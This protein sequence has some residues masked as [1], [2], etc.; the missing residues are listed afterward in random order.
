MGLAMASRR[1]RKQVATLPAWAVKPPIDTKLIDERGITPER[2]AQSRGAS[3]WGTDER[4][5]KTIQTMRD[6]PFENFYLRGGLTEKQYSAGVKYRI[7]WYR[8]GL[9][10]SLQSID[11]NRVFAS[12]MNFD[13]LAR[14][15]AQQFHRDQYRKAVQEI[16]VIPAAV[17]ETIACY[18]RQLSD[19]GVKM[20]WKSTRKGIMAAEDVLRDA[21][22][23]LCKFWG[24]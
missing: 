7:H 18:E 1:K 23:V 19:V 8:A 11:A 14:T 12:D 20:G 4:G 3:E 24:M 6:A 2:E 17:L 22:D 16:G 13:G 15:E 10:G 9:A 21:L 5:R